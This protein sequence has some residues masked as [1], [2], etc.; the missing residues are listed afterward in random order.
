MQRVLI[1]CIFIINILCIQS[2]YIPKTL[3]EE[4]ILN[5][6]QKKELVLGLKNTEFDN[7][8][9][10]GESLNSI[11]ED[12]FSNYLGLN[13]K[14]IKGTWKELLEKYN[15]NE[16]DILGVMAQ[17]ENVK[18][19]VVFTLPLYSD[20]LYL[21]SSEFSLKNLDNLNNQNIFTRE[22]SIYNKYL[23]NFLSNNGINANIIEVDTVY[24]KKDKIIVTTKYNITSERNKIKIGY[25][26]DKSIAL[27]SN[28][29]DLANI[30]DNTLL[31]KYQIKIKTFLKNRVRF[32]Y[33]TNFKNSLT[34]EEN[35]YLLNNKVI[36]MAFESNRTFS[37]YSKESNKFI[38]PVQ[39]VLDKINDRTGL[40]FR[41]I[42]DKNDR[43]L[44]AYGNFVG[45]KADIIPLVENGFV[46]NQ[47]LTTPLYYPN[48][49]RV[50]SFSKKRSKIG[51]VKDS[52]EE[53]FAREYYLDKNIILY[54]TYPEL[55]N[56]L[57]NKKIDDILLFD[58]N[59][60][61][62]QNYNIDTFITVP[63]YLAISNNNVI[64]QSILN[65]AITQVIDI[66]KVERDANS[67]KREEEYN[68]YKKYLFVNKL[69]YIALIL[70]VIF[71]LITLYKN[72][73]NKILD[74]EKIGRASFRERVLRLV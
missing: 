24:N 59:K 3:K 63:M 11:L 1:C 6:Y 29:S 52:V 27:K 50:S 68:R 60:F 7:E 61:D 31:E 66:D 2:A 16:I 9:I 40:E 73:I 20:S 36:T 64:L 12:M 41:M 14:V 25:L 53:S 55:G 33:R 30:V 45:G 23:N 48:L 8:V 56:A 65:K 18:D 32:I 67:L 44:N 58:L 46:E 13:I 37:V 26:P 71:L 19:D 72:I 38:G 15:N 69:I 21:S 22:G 4:A 49:Y 10:N 57:I 5:A 39:V 70:A 35:E 17:T 47:I 74:K 43:W 54:D 34:E 42:K 62:I 28:M 51:V